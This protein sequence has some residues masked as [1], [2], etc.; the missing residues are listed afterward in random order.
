MLP[1]C[2]FKHI[3]W[4]ANLVAHFLAK[5]ALSSQEWGVMR[6]DMP[7]FVRS[8]VEVEAVRVTGSSEACNPCLIDQ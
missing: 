4:D 6:F 7:D 1:G 5:H 2:C 8:Q 3:S